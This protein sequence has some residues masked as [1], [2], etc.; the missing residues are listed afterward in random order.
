MRVTRRIRRRGRLG[1]IAGRGDE[2]GIGKA[3]GVWLRCGIMRTGEVYD[4]LRMW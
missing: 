4:I 2:V 1:I 3:E